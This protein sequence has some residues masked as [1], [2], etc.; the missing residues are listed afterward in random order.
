MKTLKAILITVA[1]SLFLL[2][3]LI[4]GQSEIKI[5]KEFV[6]E[7]KE[8]KFTLEQIKPYQSLPKTTL[9]GFLNDM[10]SKA[11][12]EEWEKKPEIFHVDNQISFLIPLTF[13]KYTTT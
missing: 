7:L 9:M 12:W 2:P 1:L 6:K 11:N 5:W 13:D 3:N 4:Y 10:S 8:D